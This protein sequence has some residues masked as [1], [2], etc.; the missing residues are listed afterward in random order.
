MQKEIFELKTQKVKRIC[1]G[2]EEGEDRETFEQ[3]GHPTPVLLPGKSHGQRSLV[4]CSPWGCEE[5]DTTD[6]LHFHFSLSCIGEGNGTPSSTLAWKI[7]WM[8][9]PVGLQSMGLLRV[10]HD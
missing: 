8:E 1:I 2:K 10:G 6:R 9:E 4:G 5:S 7:P 3:Q